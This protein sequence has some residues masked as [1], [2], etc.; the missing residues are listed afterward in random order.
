MFCISGPNFVILAWTGDELLCRQARDWYTHTRTHRPTDAGYDNT[1]RQKLA[2]GKND[3]W[4]YVITMPAYWF[5]FSFLFWLG[6]HLLPSN[7]QLNIDS[8]LSI[9]NDFIHLYYIHIH[10]N[11]NTHL[12]FLNNI[13]MLGVM[14][15]NSFLPLLT[16]TPGVCFDIS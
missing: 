5:I 10:I 11:S 13:S 1:Q 8:F 2:L 12:C 14:W 16:I 15:L 7:W 3:P 6:G 9:K 4:N